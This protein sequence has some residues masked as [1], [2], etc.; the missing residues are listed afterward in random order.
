MDEQNS[1][2]ETT[3]TTKCSSE[4]SRRKLALITTA[5]RGWRKV[6]PTYGEAL[7]RE[8]IK[9]YFQTLEDLDE[10]VL[11][12]A[13][14]EVGKTCKVFPLPAH[15]REVAERAGA[16]S[17]EMEAYEALALLD[18]L[19]DEWGF[20]R[21][22]EWVGKSPAH[23]DG[24]VRCPEVAGAL[25]WALR[26]VGGWRAYAGRSERDSTFVR[27]D[28]IAS[29]KRVRAAEA[30]GWSLIESGGDGEFAGAIAAAALARTM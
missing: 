2:N 17:L 3:Q 29:F 22:P 15:I 18:R 19:I 7:D 23:P 28:M 21:T 30:S 13:L 25:G 10:A 6:Y 24:F 14:I 12:K 20:D 16:A 4:S 1:S 8:Q 5:I 9:F 27:K 11:A 26:S